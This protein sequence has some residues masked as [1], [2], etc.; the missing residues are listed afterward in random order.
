MPQARA[1]PP[2]TAAGRPSTNTIALN[3]EMIT[4]VLAKRRVG[5]VRYGTTTRTAAAATAKAIGG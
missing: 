5:R 4:S 1:S 2:S 3:A